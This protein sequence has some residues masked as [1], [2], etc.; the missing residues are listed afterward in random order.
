MASSPSRTH[1]RVGRGRRRVL[2]EKLTDT[3]TP[4]PAFRATRLRRP[5]PRRAP[6]RSGGRCSPSARRGTMKRAGG[7]S[8]CRSARHRIS[9]SAETVRALRAS[10]CGWK[11]R[12]ARRAPAPA[13]GRQAVPGPRRSDVPC[14]SSHTAW[15]RPFMSPP[16]GR[17]ATSGA[18]A[19]RRS[20]PSQGRNHA[21]VRPKSTSTCP[22]RTARRRSPWSASGRTRGRQHGHPRRNLTRWR[23]VLGGCP[24]P[25]GT[26]AC[27]RSACRWQRSDHHQLVTP[28]P[29]HHRPGRQDPA[30]VGHRP[31]QECRPRCRA[32]GLACLADARQSD[33]GDEDRWSFGADGDPAGKAHGIGQSGLRVDPTAA[34]G[35]RRQ[36][37]HRHRSGG[38]GHPGDDRHQCGVPDP[39]AGQRASQNRAT[40]K[41]TWT[42]AALGTRNS[43]TKVRKADKYGENQAPRPVRPAQI[44]PP[45]WRRPGRQGRCT[46]RPRS[47]ACTA[48]HPQGAAMPATTKTTSQRSPGHCSKI[49]WTHQRTAHTGNTTRRTTSGL[50]SSSGM[51]SVEPR[52][53]LREEPALHRGRRGQPGARDHRHAVHGRRRPSPPPKRRPAIHQPKSTVLRP[54]AR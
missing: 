7:T 38:G 46:R 5:A 39:D 18:G 37:H 44:R 11:T 19:R 52:P 42:N 50:S 40:P 43:E 20:S 30:D 10:I 26:S 34:C 4:T 25:E 32:P 15:A 28:D 33:G 41:P 21:Q 54:P 47:A 51:P 24:E 35:R 22:W 31:A 8:P 14:G 2:P 1:E 53:D 36:H 45:P 13:G 29:A 16:V 6:T 49:A 9:A 27:G 48:P 3:G 12:R 17:R 23:S